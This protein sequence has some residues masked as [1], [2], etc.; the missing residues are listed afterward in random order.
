[1]YYIFFSHLSWLLLSSRNF[2]A[3][4]YEHDD[5]QKTNK[6]VHKCKK[7][8]LFVIKE[9]LLHAKIIAHPIQIYASKILQEITS[10]GLKDCLLG[11]QKGER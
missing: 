8:E 2:T 10:H 5:K 3:E 11:Y 7:V 9:L 1:M 6:K 4:A